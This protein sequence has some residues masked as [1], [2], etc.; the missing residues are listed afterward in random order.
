MC[1]E[2]Q[3]FEDSDS[4][5]PALPYTEELPLAPDVKAGSLPEPTEGE[6]DEDDDK[7]VE[8]LQGHSVSSS[9]LVTKNQATAASSGMGGNN[10]NE[11]V[12]FRFPEQAYAPLPSSSTF[13]GVGSASGSIVHL[14]HLSVSANFRTTASGAKAGQMDLDRISLYMLT[15][16]IEAAFSASAGQA[17]ANANGEKAGKVRIEKLVIEI[18]PKLEGKLRSAALERGFRIIG[19][20]SPTAGALAREGRKGWKGSIESIM[21]R[22]WPLDFTRQILVLDRNAWEKQRPIG[23]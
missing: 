18:D 4:P 5:R 2:V 7:V 6:L 19:A 8:F 20:T 1:R 10:S 3:R 9:A 13:P 14:R 23:R 16:V 15:L 21:A 17:F 11:T 12:D 22:V